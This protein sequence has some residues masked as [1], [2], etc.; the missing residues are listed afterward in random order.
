MLVKNYTMRAMAETPTETDDSSHLE[1]H[2]IAL[3]KSRREA[4]TQGDLGAVASFLAGEFHYA[5]ITGLMEN[6]DGY[7]RRMAN[8]PKLITLTSATELRV[9]LRVNYALMTGRSFIETDELAISTLFLAV[10]EPGRD[11]WKLSAYASTPLPSAVS[12]SG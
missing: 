8:Q 1:G 4:I 2:L 7:L 3:E 9:S 10:W 12:A 6:R 5:H 11:G